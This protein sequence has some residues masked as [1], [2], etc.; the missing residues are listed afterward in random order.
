M[1]TS[2]SSVELPVIDIFVGPVFTYRT[3]ISADALYCVAD[4]VIPNGIMVPIHSHA[5]RETFY[6][7]AGQLEGYLHGA[8]HVLRAGD[9]FDVVDGARH[10]LRNN[11]GQSMS[12]VLVTTSKLA[13]FFVDV[14]RPATENLPTPTAADML[15]FLEVSQ[16]YGYWMGDAADN[17]AVGIVLN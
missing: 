14:G 3:P 4:V 15:H 10:A 1:M 7:L 2:R 12:L 6:I 9:V 11:S 8:W 16:S 17:A 13:Q 5:D